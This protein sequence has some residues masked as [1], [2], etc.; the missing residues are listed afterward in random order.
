MYDN[1]HHDIT[2]STPKDFVVEV[3][4]N[5]TI[6]FDNNNDPLLQY[7]AHSV[8][9]FSDTSSTNT[10]TS[11]GSSNRTWAS[12]A[13]KS[14]DTSSI[15]TTSELSKTI[16]QL[17]EL[18]SKIFTRLDKIEDTLQTHTNAIERA[19]QFETEYQDNMKTLTGFI[20]R[21]EDRTSRMQ[22]RKLDEYYEPL[23]SN[24]RQ[25]TNRSPQKA[26]PK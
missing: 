8:D 13:S 10:W 16:Q 25:N 12:V 20:E 26:P 18:I 11:E 22:P 9:S 23:E 4:F 14:N 19:Q 1:L 3:R 21:L 6:V 5:S 7:A 17:I 15:T 2:A 24:K